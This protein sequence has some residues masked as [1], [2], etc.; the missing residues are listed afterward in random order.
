[1]SFI[2][3]TNL[4]PLSHPLRTA[5]HPGWLRPREDPPRRQRAAGSGSR[6]HAAAAAGLA[7]DGAD[8]QRRVVTP[9]AGGDTHL[10]L[11]CPSPFSPST[12]T[13][14]G[15]ATDLHAHPPQRTP[16]GVLLQ[17]PRSEPA[18]TDAASRARPRPPAL[19][20][21]GIGCPSA[22]PAGSRRGLAQLQD[23]VGGRWC[24]DGAV[25][26]QQPSYLR[27]PTQTLPALSGTGHQGA[28][29]RSALSSHLDW[30]LQIGLYR[31][32][33]DLTEK[34]TGSAG[35]VSRWTSCC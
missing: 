7:A 9:P 20:S 34:K 19:R 13:A 31:R 18:A 24:G 5:P 27:V 33:T 23:N 12:T 30:T 22:L 26:N 28:A 16:T 8:L 3:S 4:S 1:M 6:H 10:L 15:G 32:F 11:L 2:Q 29:P 14:G 17:Q 25:W 35:L 21:T